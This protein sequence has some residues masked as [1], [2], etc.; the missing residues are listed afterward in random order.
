MFLSI[1]IALII[2]GAVLALIN[3]LPIDGTIKQIIWIVAI[4]GAIVYV[5]KG[6][7]IWF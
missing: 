7:G 2:L 5:L 3:L 6:I 1:I 4:V